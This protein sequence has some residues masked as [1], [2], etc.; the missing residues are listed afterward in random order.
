VAAAEP[1]GAA[2]AYD[3]LDELREAFDARFAGDPTIRS[4]IARV[5]D[6]VADYWEG[7]AR[8]IDPA[9]HRAIHDA[10]IAPVRALQSLP[11]T[12]CKPAADALVSGW[13]RVRAT[14]P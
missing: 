10:L 6:E 13:E 12:D 14:L 4:A 11:T 3:R 7:H 8:Q 5:L 2:L 9:A 1:D